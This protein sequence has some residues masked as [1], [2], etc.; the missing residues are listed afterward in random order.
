M[1]KIYLP[2]SKLLVLLGILVYSSQAIAQ[3]TPGD[4]IALVNLYN[5]TGGSNWIR[6]NG[7]LT[8]SVSTWYGVQVSGGRVAQ[9]RLSGNN[10]AGAATDSLRNLSALRIIDFSNNAL[11]SF[12]ALTGLHLDTLSLQN[13]KLTFKDLIPN[14]NIADSFYYA[15]QDS[16]DIAIDTTVIEQSSFILV[17]Q[18][19]NNPLIGDNYHWYK[20]TTSIVSSTS[21]QYSILC[22]DSSQAGVYGCV[23]TNSQLSGLTIYRRLTTLHVRRLADPGTN[24]SLC[25][26]NTT[27]RGALPAG[28]S[29]IWTKIAGG[30]NIG[31]STSAVTGITNLTPG[32]NVFVYSVN[33]GNI[34]C[35][36]G[37]YSNAL[38]TVTR[39]TFPSAPIAGADQSVCGTQAILS[40]STPGIGIG[41][42]AVIR[43]G[44]I[45]AQPNSPTSAINGLALGQNIL[46]WNI[47]NG[48][49]TFPF[50]DEVIIYRD[51]TL[52]GANAGTDTSICPTSYNITSLQ[53]ANAH[54]SWSV[55]NGSAT[56]SADSSSQTF[57]GDTTVQTSVTGLN[58]L[59]NT[60]RYTVSN[61][62]NTVS[63]D[64]HITVYRFTTANAGPGYTFFYSPIHPFL[65]ADSVSVG[66]GGNGSY[67]Y[68]WSPSTYLDSAGLEHPHF[69]A[70]DSGS[71]TYSVT[72]TDGHGCTASASSDYHVIKK[73]LLDIPTLFTPN[74]DGVNDELYIP[75]IESYI[76]NELTVVDRN[77]Q[78]VFHKNGYTNNWKGTNEEGFG[79][80]GQP[81]APDTYFYTLKLQDGTPLQT[82]FFLIKY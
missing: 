72:V 38:I 46:R 35:P 7:W 64:L 58:E 23:I 28:G 47:S 56:F 61:S 10:L 68:V 53:P 33:A 37:S 41:T 54:W 13:N 1:N 70:P 6:H 11:T 81:L 15:P 5:G 79:Q 20:D 51:D 42:W 27:L 18:A 22:M 12:P 45:V 39:D 63:I 30:A 74:N 59:L 4:S 3:V 55:V 50:Y 65:L 31:N 80:L 73:P 16:A 71:Y 43:G 40:A 77:D 67:T 78:V 49:C 19:D 29:V 2:F 14:K 8:G 82:G 60:L 48:T 34:S 52:K 69:L 75:G 9:L 36:T 76:H 32:A 62:C 44:G 66:N 17:A 26:S 24:F 25:D 57:F 21:N